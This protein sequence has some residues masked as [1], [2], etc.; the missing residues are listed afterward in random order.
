MSCALAACSS[1]DCQVCSVNRRLPALEACGKPVA[2]KRCGHVAGVRHTC[3]PGSKGRV[4][5]PDLKDSEP[6]EEGR[7]R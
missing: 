2:G 6:I 3:R 7:S 4:E 5:A 1:P